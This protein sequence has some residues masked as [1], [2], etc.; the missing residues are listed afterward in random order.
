M[1][2]V[3]NKL[4]KMAEKHGMEVGTIMCV[5]NSAHIYMDRDATAAQ[6][7]I[8]K[9]GKG[10]TIRWDSRSVWRLERLG[11]CARCS[12]YARWEKDGYEARDTDFIGLP[13]HA[14]CVHAPQVPWDKHTLQATAL[15]PTGTDIIAVFTATA[16]GKLI[17]DIGRSGLVTDLSHAMWLGAEI[18][19]V[20]RGD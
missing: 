15:D 6:D 18:E 14:G 5:S 8:K 12:I 20:A 19:R 3:N 1:I 7:V 17:L 2:S 10:P 16:P 11:T 4:V 9:A 13:N